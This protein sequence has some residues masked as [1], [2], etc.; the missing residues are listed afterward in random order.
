MTMTAD[1][2]HR[3][4]DRLQRG[5]ITTTDPCQTYPDINSDR[6]WT[7]AELEA[8][9]GPL[10]PVV[11][12]PDDDRRRMVAALEHARQRALASALVGLYRVARECYDADG[13]DHRLLAGRPG[14]WESAL[15]PRFAWEAGVDIGASRIDPVAVST[16]TMVVHGWVFHPHRFVEVAENLAVV[17][18]DAVDRRGGWELVADQWLRRHPL[19]EDLRGFVLSRSSRFPP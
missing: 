2:P 6:A 13:H 15:L 11:P 4:V 19:S 12:M 10:R 5:W 1:R 3:V 16:T 7:L 14:S 17:L 8:E 9:R 18:G